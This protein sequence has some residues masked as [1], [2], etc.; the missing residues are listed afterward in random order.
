MF[1]RHG[2]FEEVHCFLTGFYSATKLYAPEVSREWHRFTYWLAIKKL[3]YP[4]NHD[5]C[6]YVKGD[7]DNEAALAYLRTLFDEFS[8]RP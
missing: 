1:T 5:W 4:P 2:T 8:Q 6:E 7:L 3:R